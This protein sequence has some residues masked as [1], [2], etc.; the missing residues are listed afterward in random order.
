[1]TANGAVSTGDR[2]IDEAEAATVRRVFTLYV[3]GM[4]PR[5]I[6]RTLQLE[7]IRGPRGGH[8]T[9]SLILG[10][11]ERVCDGLLTVMGKDRLG[12]A[13]HHARNICSNNRTILRHRLQA[14]IFAVLKQRLLAPELVAQFAKTYVQ[15]I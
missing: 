10:N 15:L 6:A 3:G 11:A 12:C 1:V 7:G 8:W 9:A 4:S 2:A 13:N 14:K 5:S